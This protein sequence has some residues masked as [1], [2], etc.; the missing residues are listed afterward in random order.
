MIPCVWLLPL[1]GCAGL[2]GGPDRPPAPDFDHPVDYVAWYNEFLSKHKS[3]NALELY[4]EAFAHAPGEQRIPEPSDAV[5]QQID[6]LCDGPVW[7]P[8]DHPQVA[9]YLN[10]CRP[11]LAALKKG[12]RRSH[13]WRPA[14]DGTKLLFA[15]L[16]PKLS[17]SRNAV[18][19][20]LTE[21]W[22]KQDDQAAAVLDA[23]KLSLRHARHIQ[24]SGPMIA[25]LVGI[26][27]RALVFRAVRGALHE[28]VIQG[29]AITKAFDTIRRSDRS[30]S[31]STWL[32]MEWAAALSILQYVFPGGQY[33]RSRGF[34]LPDLASIDPT[35]TARAVD[36]YFTGLLDITAGPLTYAN[37]RKVKRHCQSRH[38]SARDNPFFSS[39]LPDCSRIYELIV[40]TDACRRATL[41]VL[42]LYAHHAKQGKWP[43]SLDELGVK[44]LDELRTDPYSG[45]DFVYKLKDGS[46]MLYSVGANGLDDGGRHDAKWGESGGDYVFWPHQP[47]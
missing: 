12:A 10:K 28:G 47:K 25:T 7:G 42:A 5:S 2:L 27:E 36:D 46:P 21:A 14:P 31:A 6:A 26:S 11:Y 1:I 43:A 20:M 18:K 34:D 45:E 13:Y 15:L 4:K 29:T 37:A 24:D 8:K 22:M 41:L 44:I 16:Q 30:P 17:G 33:E 32:T 3:N 39:V 23:C 19:A 38:E 9:A 40:R 35:A